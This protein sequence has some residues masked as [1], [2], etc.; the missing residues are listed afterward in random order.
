VNLDYCNLHPTEN[1]SVAVTQ[2]LNVS[3]SGP[4]IERCEF[5]Q[6]LQRAMEILNARDLEAQLKTESASAV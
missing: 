5:E 2:R 3:H 1:N 4:R 6:L